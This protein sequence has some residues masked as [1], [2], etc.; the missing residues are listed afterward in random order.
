MVDLIRGARPNDAPPHLV[1]N[2]VG[3]P[4]RPEIPVKDFAESLGLINPLVIPFDAKLFGNAAN[5]GQMIEEINPKS[6]AAE[7]LHQLVQS[8]TRR[9]APPPPKKSALSSLF[10]RK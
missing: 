6:K 10:K 3:M 5:N 9:E 2:Q 4:G 8:I 1:L 7:V